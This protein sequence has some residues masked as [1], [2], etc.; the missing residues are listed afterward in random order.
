MA[1]KP[2][3]TYQYEPLVMPAKWTGDERQLVLRLT[4][5]MDSL[6][7]RIGQLEHRVKELEAKNDAPI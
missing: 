3:K 6:H 7:Y 4:Q 1:R 2:Q 5:I